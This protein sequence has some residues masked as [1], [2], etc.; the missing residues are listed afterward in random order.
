MP[1]DG[2]GKEQGWVTKWAYEEDSLSADTLGRLA[3][4][5]GYLQ[6]A[7]IANSTITATKVT[8]GFFVTGIYGIGIYGTATYG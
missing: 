2:A 8:S 7:K 6:N 5:D 3:M 4:E 1:V